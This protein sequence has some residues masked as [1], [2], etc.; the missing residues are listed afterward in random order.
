MFQLIVIL[1]YIGIA[2]LLFEIFYISTKWTS[3]PKILLLIFTI[4][5]L[6][7]NV[8]YLFEITSVT[9]ETAIIGTKFS[10][11]GKA[12]LPLIMALFTLQNC[13]IKLP[14]R[15]IKLLMIIHSLIIFLVLTSEHNTLYYSSVGYDYEGG[16]FPH[17]VLGHGIIY[18]CY[19]ILIMA[20]M[21]I[22]PIVMIYFMV[23]TEDKD[24]RRQLK[25][26]LMMI[27]VT[28]LGYYP[29]IMGLTAGYD[30]TAISYIVAT[31]I[32]MYA[33]FHDKL[34][35]TVDFAKDYVIDNLDD[36][37]IVLGKNDELVFY[38]NLAVK[39]LPTLEKNKGW[40]AINIV[41]SYANN[42]EELFYEEKVYNITEVP[43]IAEKQYGGKMFFLTDI[44]DSYNYTER[45]KADVEEKTR[46]I[47][48]I[49]RSVIAS[50]ANMVE[51]RDGVTGLH[52]KNTSA[53]VEIIVNELKKLPKYK[54][55]I[56]DETARIMVDAAP[57][58]DIGKIAVKDSI[59][60]K[61]GKLTQEEFEMIKQ[62]AVAGAQIIDET[63]AEVEK[64][65]YLIIARNMAHYHHER[66]DGTGYPSGLKGEQIP[67]CARVMAIA[68]VY[69]ALRS[70][71][72]YKDGF[73]IEKSFQIMRE[74]SGTHFDPDLLDI[75]LA[76]V[77]KIDTEE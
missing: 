25:Y 27:L 15:V 59:L 66:W 7:N 8:G 73:S 57:L 45:L 12:F 17:L 72:S 16:L 2:L 70:K 11:L 40:D 26:L 30:T 6:I 9:P 4:A 32:F 58:H 56:D 62:H 64:N 46:E 35:D 23:K 22:L 51:A 36:G 42:D 47:N 5:T 69:D 53:Y 28:W 10:Y 19:M 14:Q 34:F 52:I 29:F 75:F 13:K 50:F 54:N 71:R 24:D 77:L 39:L 37:L 60:T 63:L 33:V 43:I 44:T 67:L 20:Y 31:V 41:E 48:H 49:Q 68:D 55:V 74:S 38:N 3:R 21:T 76:N 18:N 65:E 61:P 1:Q